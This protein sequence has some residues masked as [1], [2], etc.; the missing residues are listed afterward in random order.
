MATK[1]D[2]GRNTANT[3][4]AVNDM[5]QPALGLGRVTVRNS[6]R[7]VEVQES[8]NFTRD[9]VRWGPIWGGLLTT[10]TVFLLLSLLGLAIGLTN[11]PTGT[12][13][14]GAISGDTGRNSALWLAASGIISFLIG[15][16][17]AGKTAAVF[18]RKWGAL[19]GALIFF[20]AVPLI[21]W[22]ASV[23][24]GANLG[25]LGNSIRHNLGLVQSATTTSDARNA[26]WGTLIALLV[27]LLASAIGGYLGTRRP[28]VNRSTGI[29]HE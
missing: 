12:V 15:G 3:E 25:G 14:S 6:L 21:I 20:L 8:T 24:A 28:E 22:L 29:V 19:N 4:I 18:D 10:L 23:G 27:A 1:H 11:V 2:R 26:A 9:R 7:D 17:L 13:G 5:A 16:Y